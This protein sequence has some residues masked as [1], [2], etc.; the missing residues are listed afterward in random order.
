LTKCVVLGTGPSLAKQRDRILELH[1]KGEIK[2][3]GVNNTFADFPV[4]VWIACDPSW[5]QHYGQVVGDFDKW[6]WDAEI[7]QK[8]GYRHI[9]GLWR[10][11][12]SLDPQYIHF[13]HSSGF[14]ALNLAY[15]YGHRDIY[16]AGYDMH[17]N[18]PRHYFDGLSDQAGEYPAPLR[19]FS[20][21]DKPRVEKGRCKEYSLFQYYESVAEQNPC[22]IYNMT[23]DSAL[24]CFEFKDL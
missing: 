8:Y 12:I 10:D 22:N 24:K 18:G 16:L 7:C 5:H 23:A 1:A 4:D 20:K 19:K 15:H 9:E 21:F 3:F 6:H 11:G 2:I 14:Q 13:G 17:Y